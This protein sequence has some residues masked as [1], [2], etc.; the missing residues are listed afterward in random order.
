M[1]DAGKRRE[2]TAL[3]I[4]FIPVLY[5]VFASLGERRRHAG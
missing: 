2:V 1:A 5:V 3:G 4:F